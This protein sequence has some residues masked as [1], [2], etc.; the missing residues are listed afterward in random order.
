MGRWLGHSIGRGTGERFAGRGHGGGSTLAHKENSVLG[1]GTAVQPTAARH[2]GSGSR[3]QALAR[4][5]SP[6]R[7]R[8][9]GCRIAGI[10]NDGGRMAANYPTTK[11]AGKWSASSTVC[12]PFT[13]C[14]YART[15]FS[16]FPAVD[17]GMARSYDCATPGWHY[18]LSR[19]FL[20]GSAV[21]CGLY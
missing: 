7:D 13:A 15:A 18:Q 4:W 16:A 19:V 9:F 8:T 3:P 11:N 1:R 12:K 5:G 2:R 20:L 10:A 6:T 21:S 14:L 17:S